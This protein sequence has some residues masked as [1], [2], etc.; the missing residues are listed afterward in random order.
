MKISM[1]KVL[2]RADSRGQANFGWLFSRHTFSFD[3]YH[4]HERM[5]FGKL[6][7]IND[8]VVAPGRGFE[9]HPHDNMEIVSIPL[10][11]SLRHEDNLGNKHIIRA[12]EIQL[13]SAGTGITHSEYNDSNREQVNFLQI[14]VIPKVRYVKPY[15]DQKTFSPNDRHNC[16]QVIV[17]PDGYNDS[18]QINQIAWFSL[19]SLDTEATTNY[20]IHHQGYGVY[21]FV[22]DGQIQVC[23]EILD[24]RDGIGLTDVESFD[25]KAVHKTEVLCIEVPM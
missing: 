1:N 17:S 22:I 3:D 19:G 23:G 18:V 5:G 6:R 15:Y 7:V 20:R 16:F 25:V 2:H 8:D 4:D 12:G 13:M 10:S 11:G 21:L 9:T 24:K 14:W